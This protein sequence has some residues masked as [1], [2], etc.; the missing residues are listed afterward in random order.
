MRI[1]TN[2]TKFALHITRGLLITIMLNKKTKR[3]PFACWF[4]Y[5]TIASSPADTPVAG[6]L[7]AVS[8]LS[9]QIQ[10]ANAMHSD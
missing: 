1:R 7:Y 10:N 2:Q 6:M 3:T 9:M 4:M 8:S 5:Q